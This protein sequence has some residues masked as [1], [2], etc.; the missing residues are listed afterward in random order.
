MP[1]YRAVTALVSVPVACLAFL[2]ASAVTAPPAH[3][4]A[5]QGGAAKPTAAVANRIA[6]ESGFSG[7]LLGRADRPGNPTSDHPSGYAVDFMVDSRREG[8]R[9]AAAA[10]RTPGVKYVLW[11]VEDHFDHVHVSVN[12]R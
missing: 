1:R 6:K 12:R 10:R 5:I 8:D 9:V 3:A 2:L 4:A 7:T 11:R